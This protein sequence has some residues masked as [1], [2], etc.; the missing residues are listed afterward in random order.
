MKA[1]VIVAFMMC[2]ALG[3]TT[4]TLLHKVRERDRI[5]ACHV[6]ERVAHAGMHRGLATCLSE[7]DQSLLVTNVAYLLY[8]DTCLADVVL[9]TPYTPEQA[10][11]LTEEARLAKVELERPSM[12][13]MAAFL[14]QTDP[15]NRVFWPKLKA[16]Q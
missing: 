1:I 5:I 13:N 7:G 11:L 6:Y 9:V 3:A 12:T 4:L 2:V 8:M 15:L 10:A 16:N 14:N